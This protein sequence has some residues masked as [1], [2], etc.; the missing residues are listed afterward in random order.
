MTEGKNAD[1]STKMLRSGFGKQVKSV[2]ASNPSWGFGSSVRESS[3]KVGMNGYSEAQA[4]STS[5]KGSARLCLEAQM[6]A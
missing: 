5:C 3:T 1:A 4:L 6:D 2:S